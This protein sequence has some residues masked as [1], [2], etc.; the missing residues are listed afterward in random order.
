MFYKFDR[1][2][3]VFKKLSLKFYLKAAGFLTGITIL[4]TSIGVYATYTIVPSRRTVI[5]YD[6]LVVTGFTEEEYIRYMKEVNIKFPHIV[7]AQSMIETGSFSSEIFKHNH[8]LFGM[9]EP[10][11][12]ATVAKGTSRGHAYYDHWTQSVVDY[13]LFQSRYMSH[14]KS[15]SAYLEYLGKHYAEDPNYVTKVKK[16]I[17][18]EN[19]EFKIDQVW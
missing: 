15:E 19:L 10:S 13:A 14:L 18:R 8:N 9:K 7:L 3:L 11:S 12:R 4:G 16:L 1:E 17:E 5:N 6:T 2:A